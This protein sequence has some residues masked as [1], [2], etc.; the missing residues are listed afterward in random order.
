[1]YTNYTWKIQNVQNKLIA[2]LY[3][4]KQDTLRLD[5]KWV[6][7]NRGFYCE[8]VLLPIINNYLSLS[9]T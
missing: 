8:Q 2:Q 7:S 3:L 1:M 6:F 5:T 4:R 9:A